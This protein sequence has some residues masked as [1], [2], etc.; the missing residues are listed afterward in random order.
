MHIHFKSITLT[1]A[2]A[3]ILGL[4]SC[5]APYGPPVATTTSVRTYS[6]GYSVRSLPSNYRSE[7]IGGADYYY[8][9]G[10]YYQRRNTG[11]VVVAAPRKSRY[12]N[13]YSRYSRSNVRPATT[14]S[15][16]TIN[17]LPRGYET[18]RYRGQPYYRY[19]NNYYRR[20]GSGYITVANP[21]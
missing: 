5:V 17:R 4:T 19:Q 2:A 9:N 3:T 13:E 8:H 6:P 20:Q 16:R 12:Y 14:R 7:R 1:A 21:F 15:A 18:V 10:S 11:Y